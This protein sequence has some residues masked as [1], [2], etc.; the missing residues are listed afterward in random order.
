MID[1]EMIPSQ[2]RMCS[3]CPKMCRHVCPTFFAWRSDSPTPHG[4]ALL[5]HQEIMGTR[6]LDERGIEVLYQCLECSHCLTWCLPEI[7]IAEIVEHRRTML[8]RNGQYPVGLDSMVANVV[9]HHNPFG[10]PHSERTDWIRVKPN[11]GKRIAYFTGCTSAYREKEIAKSTV[12]LLHTLGFDVVLPDEW[13]CGSPL[14]RTGFVDIGLEQASHNAEVLN[15]LE[16]EEIVATCPGCYRTLK[17]DYAKLGLEL[18]VPVRHISEFLEEHIADLNFGEFDGKF[19]FH[20]PCH[21]GRHMGVYDSP[22]KVIQHV[23]RS[24]VIEMERHGDNAM[25]CGNGA[26]MRLLWPEKAKVIGSE[27]IRQA[28][29]IDANVLVTACPFCKNL[30]VSQSDNEMKVIDLPELALMAIE[31]KNAHT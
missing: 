24:K 6:Q 31:K 3:A 26:G 28:K 13:C 15:S 29:D 12:E 20:D 21:L 7:D 11:K 10:E 8:V 30:L 18:D 2:V 27:R 23:T 16:V 17:N 1:P 25:C 5:I 9:E 19:T 4:R 22:R 14:L